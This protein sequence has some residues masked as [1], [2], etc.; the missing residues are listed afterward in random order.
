MEKLKRHKTLVFTV[1][2]FGILYSLISL[3][4]HYNFRTYALDLG[5]Y[6]NA[7][8]DYSHFQWND[9]TAFKFVEE[10]LL[11]DHFDLYLILFS[12]LS[13][14]FG[15]YTLQVIQ[16]L[17]LLFG[18]VGVYAYF[19]TEKKTSPFA[20]YASLYF[21]IFFGVFAA[22]SYDYHSNVIAAALIPW[23]F[24]F[25]KK[26]KLLFATIL[27]VLILISKENI[28]LWFVFI[29]L[30]LTIE[31]RKTPYIRNFLI[32]ASIFSGIFFILITSVVMPSFSNIGNYPHFH[33]GFLGEN[34]SEAI[35]HLI[36][37]PVESFKVLFTNH[38][39]HP[40]GDFVK[41]ELHLLLLISGLPLLIK[42]PQ[43]LLMLVPIYFQKLFHDNYS[44]WGIGGQYSIEFAPIL[45]VGIFSVLA[46]FKKRKRIKTVSIVV[47]ILALG[48]TIRTMDNTVFF[49]NKSTI[50]FYKSSHYSRDYN[51]Q[52]VHVQLNKIPKN[53]IVSAQSPF[54][55]HLALRDNIY[56]F[57]IIKDAE[58]VIFSKNEN[59]YP[60]TKEEFLSETT[61]IK[62]SNEWELIYDDEVVILRKVK[63]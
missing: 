12:P 34:F 23:F 63:I 30:G 47:V 29:C 49:T 20:I 62:N 60:L 22:V 52:N 39:N 25:V 5:A 9:S 6:T 26:G 3:V 10:N 31:Y 44:M 8:Y 38:I 14:I 4:N 56:Q 33:Y 61:L 51:V 1:L 24:L 13:L 42:K 21:Y 50:R 53:A 32:L 36:S 27:I 55:P 28:S 45:S 18:G 43:Y 17:F 11:A 57:P 48:A 40:N 16:I 46:D 35:V 59:S 41:L 7:L 58:Y 54:L 15:T 2:F 37:H 19:K